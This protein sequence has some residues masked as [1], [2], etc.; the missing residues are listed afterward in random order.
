MLETVL[1]LLTFRI[2]RDE[3]LNLTRKHF[4]AGLIGTWLVGIGRYWD[5]AGASLLQHT[6][7]GSVIYIFLLSLFI[8]LIVKP[9][10]VDNWHYGTVLTF[11]SLT[12]FPAIFYAIP[13]EQFTPLATANRINVWFLAIVAAW[14]LGLLFYFLRVFT[15]LGVNY[16]ITITLMPICLIISTLTVLNL[17]RAVFDIMGGL[18]NATP[19][20][21]AYAVLVALTVVSAVLTLPLLLV[22]CVAIIRR[23]EQRKKEKQYV[24]P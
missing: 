23:S 21:G 7:L 12:S 10:R 22:Y 16:I 19:H 4:I 2:T 14:R 9:L 1:R 13:V 8:W 18:R 17:Q 6:G 20:D 24:E 15:W 11:I 3:L 5:D